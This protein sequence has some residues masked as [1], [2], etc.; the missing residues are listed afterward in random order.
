MRKLI[1]NAI[2]Y[3]AELPSAEQLTKHLEELPYAEIGETM[4]S[5]PS[6]VPN[7][8]SNELVTKFKG[9]FAFHLRYD[10]KILPKTIVKA[11]AAERIAAIE[12]RH[13]GRLKKA[14]RQAIYDQTLVDLAKTA[15]VKTAIIPAFYREADQLLIVATGSKNL[16]GILLHY[17]IH[18]V[19]SV[20][21]TSITISDIKHG[22]T[23]RLKKHLEGEEDSFEGFE[24]GTSVA[25]KRQSEKVS[26]SLEELDTSREGLLEVMNK[27]FEVER[28]ALV[29]EGVEFKLT[30]DFQFKAVRF[31]DVESDDDALDAVALWQQE[32]A[33]QVLQFTAVINQL[34]D[35]FGYQPEEDEQDAA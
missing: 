6:F 10:E 14:D 27:G 17:L 7:K 5:R 8:T 28:L 21:T 13:G 34:C 12:E 30:S 3:K 11:K 1:P 2:V 16:A 19:G 22:I 26:F 32:A 35:I 31:D 23:T 25:L 24:L 33:V 18:V 15:L 4:L 9:G 29:R 20:K